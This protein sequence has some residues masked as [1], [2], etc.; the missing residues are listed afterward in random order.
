MILHYIQISLRNLRKYKTQTAISIAAMAVSLTLMAL[1]SSLLLMIKPSTFLHQ[2]FFNR[3]EKFSYGKDRSPYANYEDLSL[4]TSHHLKNAEEIHYLEGATY[5]MNVTSDPGSD[6]ERSLSTVGTTMDSGFMKFI[7]SKSAITGDIVS[8]VSENEVIITDWL[9]KKLFKEKNPIG[10]FINLEFSYY[11]GSKINQNFKIKDVIESQHNIYSPIPS[12][13]N[14]FLLADHLSKGRKASCFFILK[15]G[16]SR[17]SLR[18]ELNDLIPACDIQLQHLS[19]N[20]QEE[21]GILGVRNIAI[22]FLFLFVLVS[23]SNFL[24]Q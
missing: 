19:N 22:L 1:V 12:R 18:Q 11:D 9:S 20:L 15:E 3:I 24:R 5:F 17:D 2:P 7:G 10:R 21:K 23:F 6:Y 8:S 4:M 13:C 16:A 14:V